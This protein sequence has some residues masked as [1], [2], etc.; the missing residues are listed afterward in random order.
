MI[1]TIKSDKLT[2]KVNSFGAELCSVCAN[3]TEYIWQGEQW[4][5]HAPV[6]FPICGRILDGKYSY[7][8][9]EYEI[10]KHGFANASDFE[11]VSIEDDRLVLKLESN[12]QTLESYPF[13]F[14]LYADFRAVGDKLTVDFKLQSRDDKAMPHQFG[15]HPAF[16][17]FGEFPINSFTLDIGVDCVTQHLLTEAKY[18]SG[19]LSAYPLE[20]G[21]YTLSEEEIYS[22]DTLIF[23]DTS[24]SVTLACPGCERS[25]TLT[26]SDNLPY[27][28]IWKWP[29]SA[30]RYICLE[31]WCG[32][33]SDGVTPEV[34][35][36]R[37][38]RTLVPHAEE[39][40]SYEIICK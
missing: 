2:A 27:L 4:K 15:W 30:A 34:L 26:Y 8:G 9:K 11:L 31:P 18:V 5:S 36:K 23:S 38:S 1:Y 21:K 22:Q 14:T 7:G 6:L 28:A 16:T 19:A 35:D 20:G 10:K 17:L 32:I 13:E 12:E 33:P 24:G 37:V 3:N 25:L 39:I 29:D 40:Y